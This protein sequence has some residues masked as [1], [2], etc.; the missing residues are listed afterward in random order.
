MISKLCYRIE[1]KQNKN[2]AV[3]KSLRFSSQ[4]LCKQYQA[5]YCLEFNPQSF[6]AFLLCPS[7]E[8]NA[9][10]RQDFVKKN[11]LWSAAQEEGFFH[12]PAGPGL[13][14]KGIVQ[15]FDNQKVWENFDLRY[16]RFREVK[17]SFDV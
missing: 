15:K 10:E 17:R 14:V 4:F 16:R 12:K 3:F 7:P 5:F 8:Y 6:L 13:D 9:F 2:F 1:E 11:T